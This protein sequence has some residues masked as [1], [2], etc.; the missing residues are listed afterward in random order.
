M[1]KIDIESMMD[2]I[3]MI[4]QRAKDGLEPLEF[5]EMELLDLFLVSKRELLND[6][7]MN[8]EE[9]ISSPIRFNGVAIEKL[10]QIFEK[11]GVKYESPF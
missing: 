9:V 7:L 5:L 4:L 11:N 6:L 8:Q 10:K 3:Q 2:K 1:A